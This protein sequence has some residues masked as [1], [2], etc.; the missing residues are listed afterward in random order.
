M[1]AGKIF[2]LRRS[3]QMTYIHNAHIAQPAFYLACSRILYIV[4]F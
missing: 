1:V 3:V 4:N 2:S